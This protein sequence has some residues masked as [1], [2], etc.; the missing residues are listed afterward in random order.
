[1]NLAGVDLVSIRLVVLC[2]EC[3]SLSAA[4]RLGNMS[5]SA[6]SHRLTNLESFFKTRLFGRDHRGLHLTE[7]GAVFLNH[8]QVVLQI[9]HRLN[10]DLL[11]MKSDEPAQPAVSV[12]NMRIA[13]ALKKSEYQLTPVCPA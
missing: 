10:D 13:E 7:A 3:G 8:A 1:M 11:S 4:A 2:A 12:A 5:L 9:L 6:A